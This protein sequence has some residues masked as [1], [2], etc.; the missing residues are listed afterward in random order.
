MIYG[1]TTRFNHERGGLMTEKIKNNKWL[2]P[3]LMWISKKIPLKNEKK[4]KP[5]NQAIGSPVVFGAVNNSQIMIITV[6]VYADQ[7][8]KKDR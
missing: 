3:I 8:M 4:D 6:V 1:V 2:G 7:S 5:N